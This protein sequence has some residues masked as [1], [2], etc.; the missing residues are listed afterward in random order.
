MRPTTRANARQPGARLP[1]GVHTETHTFPGA[2]VCR[3]VGE[4]DVDTCTGLADPL[5]RALE[6]ARPPQELRA[7]L[8]GVRYFSAAGLAALLRLG[9]ATEARRMQLVLVAP[10]AV[11]LRVLEVSG[12]YTL[13]TVCPDGRFDGPDGDR[14]ATGG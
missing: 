6:R 2:V 7:D 12:A 5:A 9:A 14:P 13:F 8:S 3:V 11:V 10:S 4:V 1:W